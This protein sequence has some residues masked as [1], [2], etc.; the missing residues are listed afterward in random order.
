MMMDQKVIRISKELHKQL[1]VRA[2]T[3]DAS[4][5]DTAEGLLYESLHFNNLTPITPKGNK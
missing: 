5:S 4:I 2:S 1:K 3:N